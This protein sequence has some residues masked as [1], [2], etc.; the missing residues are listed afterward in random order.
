MDRAPSTITASLN[1]TAALSW[2]STGYADKQA[3]SRRWKGSRLLR[4]PDLQKRFSPAHARLVAGQVA[5]RLKK[6][7]NVRSSAM[8]RSIGLSMPDPRTKDFTWVISCPGRATRWRG[9]KGQS[10]GYIE[11][12]SPS[13][14][15]AYIDKRR[16]RV[17]GSD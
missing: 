16:Q 11:G 13:I 5:G 3:K 4:D 7:P 6:D 14:S 15:A 2:L 10:R 12:G 8:S 9:R 1:A 17:T